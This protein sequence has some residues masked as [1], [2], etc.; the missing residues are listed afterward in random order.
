MANEFGHARS[1]KPQWFLFK[2]T[3]ETFWNRP[4]N[5]IFF[6]DLPEEGQG[7]WD[8][9]TAVG[10]E[11]LRGH[12]FVEIKNSITVDSYESYGYVYY[13]SWWAYIQDSSCHFKFWYMLE[14]GIVSPLHYIPNPWMMIGDD[15]GMAPI[16]G[17]ARASARPKNVPE[18]LPKTVHETTYSM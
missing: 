16:L 13:I 7:A 11:V 6:V 10:K 9:L 8:F 17:H 14:V 2:G 4:R 1:C 18:P 12:S 5:E 3:T 15:R